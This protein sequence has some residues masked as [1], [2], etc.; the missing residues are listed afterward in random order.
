MSGRDFPK[1]APK[2]IQYFLLCVGVGD[3]VSADQTSSNPKICFWITWREEGWGDEFDKALGV[4]K[5]ET[6]MLTAISRPY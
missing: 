4:Y 5:L 2:L 6:G 3:S 1:V